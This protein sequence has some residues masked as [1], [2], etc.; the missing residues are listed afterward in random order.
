MIMRLTLARLVNG[1]VPAAPAATAVEAEN[2][3][4]GNGTMLRTTETVLTA[5]T[6]ALVPVLAIGAV[7]R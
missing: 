2:D 6:L 7:L 1:F 3:W 4:Q 5:A